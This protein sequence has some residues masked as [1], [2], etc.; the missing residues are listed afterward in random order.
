MKTAA[1]PIDPSLRGIPGAGCFYKN[2]PASS[3]SA[4]CSPPSSASVPRIFT[5][6]EHPPAAGPAAD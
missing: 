3:A 5:R 2:G 4:R 6:L 1:G